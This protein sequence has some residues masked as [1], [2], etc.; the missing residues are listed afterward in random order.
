MI[1]WPMRVTICFYSY[2]KDLTGC[3]QTSESMPEGCTLDSLY[4]KLTER[5]PRLAAFEK[6]TLMAVG[7]DYRPR[8][9]V[10]NEGDEISLF[11]PVQG[12]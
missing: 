1:N 11:P 3:G 5:F 12:G 6:S 4:R 8:G 9:Y 7:V 2:F 10:L